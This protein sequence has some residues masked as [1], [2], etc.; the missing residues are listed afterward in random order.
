MLAQ[1]HQRGAVTIRTLGAMILTV[2]ATIGTSPPAISAEIKVLSSRTISTVFEVVG[3]EFERATGHKLSV[4]TG[5][6]SELVAR[7]NNAEPFDVIAVPPPAIDKLIKEGKVAEGSRVL[8]V[9]SDV[10]VGVRTGAPKPDISTVEAFKQTLL[11]AK[12]ITYLPVPGIPQ[13]L[14]PIGIA[15]AIQSKT[16]VPTTD[17][18]S[19]LVAKGEVE[20]VIVVITQIVTT[21][22]VELVG[23]LPPEIKISSTFAGA[24]SAKSQSPHAARD[25]LKF[26]QSD[27]ALTVIRKQAMEPIL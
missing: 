10:G 2:C 23:P 18:V 19:E 12:S 14:S 6:S 27:T 7:I 15:D 21:H 26:L 11:N 16:T 9:R 1:G 20:L 17:I 25:L 8:L 3:P 4:V 5:L 24:V 13:M 22:G